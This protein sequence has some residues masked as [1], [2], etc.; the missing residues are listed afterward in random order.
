MGHTDLTRFFGGIDC[1]VDAFETVLRTMTER[2][3][4]PCV[5]T[6][7]GHCHEKLG[8]IKGFVGRSMTERLLNE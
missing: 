5:I 8:L 6:S 4:G 2:I 7:V 1:V 3:N